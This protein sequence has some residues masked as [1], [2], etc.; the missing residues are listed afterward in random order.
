VPSVL[1]NAPSSLAKPHAKPNSAA[2]TLNKVAARSSGK[3]QVADA[4]TRP[5]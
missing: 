4:I 1:S 3:N 2:A 5:P